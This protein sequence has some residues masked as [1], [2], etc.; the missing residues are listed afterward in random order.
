MCKQSNRRDQGNGKANKNYPLKQLTNFFFFFLETS[1]ISISKPYSYACPLF[2]SC[3]QCLRFQCLIFIQSFSF[4]L[5]FSSFI[6]WIFF[7]YCSIFPCLNFSQTLLIISHLLLCFTMSQLS[8]AL[9]SLMH[10][11]IPLL[12]LCAPFPTIKQLQAGH[13]AAEQNQITH[14]APRK[15]W[16]LPEATTEGPTST[17]T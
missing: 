17:A 4:L 11:F 15:A 6:T 10:S 16:C 14:G 1:L 8:L 2:P 5:F 13:A 3:M 9:F 7:P 12:Q